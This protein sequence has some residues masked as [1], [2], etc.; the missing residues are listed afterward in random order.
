MKRLTTGQIAERLGV[1]PLTI[2]NWHSSGKLIPEYVDPATNRR[3]YT[4]DQVYEFNKN[5]R[6]PE[7]NYDMKK[8]VAYSRDVLES[9]ASEQKTL[10]T[11]YLHNRGITTNVIV[12]DKA[13]Y[14]YSKLSKIIEGIL[15]GEIENLIIT[16][17]KVIFE[18]NLYLIKQILEYKNA[19]LIITD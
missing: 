1:T 18:E 12:E 3:Y 10:I 2:R 16:D 6:S 15:E 17:E 4:E 11:E 8:L 14:R 13:H 7:Y 5:F 9:S 19:K